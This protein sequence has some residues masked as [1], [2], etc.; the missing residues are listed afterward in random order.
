[1]NEI[2]KIITDVTNDDHRLRE[3]YTNQEYEP[4]IQLY[5]ENVG[6]F[7]FLLKSPS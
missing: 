5:S 7:E 1:M 3:V 4:V 6:N 2:C